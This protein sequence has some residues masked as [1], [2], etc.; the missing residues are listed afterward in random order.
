[1]SETKHI[2][3]E[4]QIEKVTLN[5]GCGVDHALLDKSV[6]LLESITN[7][8]AVRTKSKVRLASWGLRKGLPI[9][10]KVTIR[11][12]DAHALVKRLVEAKEFQLKPTSFDSRG[13][14]SFGISE[15]IDIPGVE[16]TPDI[17][18]IGLQVTITFTKP[19]TRVKNRKY[20]PSHIPAR[21]LVQRDEAIEYMAKNFGVSLIQKEDEEDE[22]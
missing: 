16:Y 3:Q 18:I 7:K 21:H 5:C 8:T 2:M 9:G 14:V 10:A 13:N 17:G 22:E 6:K 4:L 15:C 20:R 1:M 12:Q 11:G 19:G